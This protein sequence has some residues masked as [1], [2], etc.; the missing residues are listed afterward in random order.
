MPDQIEVPNYVKPWYTS[1]TLWLNI[2][3]FLVIAIGIVIDSA[4]I[5]D[6]PPKMLAYLGVLLAILNALLRFRTAQPIGAKRAD[7]TIDLTRANE[8]GKT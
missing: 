3:G 5:L 1:R 4:S 2:A 8:R 7:A 6:L